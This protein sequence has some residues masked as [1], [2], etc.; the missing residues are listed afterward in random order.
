M[1]TPV[2]L[3]FP[4]VE[5]ITLLSRHLRSAATCSLSW[6]S[7][8]W[9]WSGGFIVDGIDLL[10]ADVAQKQRRIVR[11]QAEPCSESPHGAMN[12][13]CISHLLFLATGNPYSKNS[14]FTAVQVEIPAVVRPGHVGRGRAREWRPLLLSEVEHCQ[15]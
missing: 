13:L 7:E 9:R 15:F 10:A 2:V 8:V 6:G 14:C 11:G 5:F 12:V 1:C 3:T 4:R